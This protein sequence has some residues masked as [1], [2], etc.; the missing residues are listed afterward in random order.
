MVPFTDVHR[1]RHSVKVSPSSL[2]EAV[3]L[4]MVE[5]KR[6]QLMPARLSVGGSMTVRVTRHHARAAVHGG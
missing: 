2:Y 5:F 4:A 1:I 6:S 3:T